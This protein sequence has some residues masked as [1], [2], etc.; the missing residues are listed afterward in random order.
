MNFENYENFEKFVDSV[1]F[2]WIGLIF[3]GILMDLVDVSYNFRGCGGIFVDLV[4]F[5]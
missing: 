2:S 4:E 1:D 3:R 5:S